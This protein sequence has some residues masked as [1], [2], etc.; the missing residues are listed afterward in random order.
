M[1]VLGLVLFLLR[2]KKRKELPAHESPENKSEGQADRQPK[3]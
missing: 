2:T 1:A 3:N